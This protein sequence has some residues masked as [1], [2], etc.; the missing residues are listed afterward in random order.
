MQL[1][2][3]PINATRPGVYTPL[4]SALS[5]A[6]FCH[7]MQFGQVWRYIPFF[8]FNRRKTL[9][10]VVPNCPFAVLQWN[11]GKGFIQSRRIQREEFP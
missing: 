1:L 5:N 10:F 6:S 2:T 9:P 4:F 3:F 7:F 11:V 8:L